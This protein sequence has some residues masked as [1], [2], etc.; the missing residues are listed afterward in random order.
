MRIFDT[1]F[2]ILRNG[3]YRFFDH[4]FVQ[5]WEMCGVVNIV[6]IVDSICFLYCCFGWI[7]YVFLIKSGG[8][9]SYAGKKIHIYVFRRKSCC[10]CCFCFPF[11]FL[12]LFRNCFLIF[13]YLGEKIMLFDSDRLCKAINQHDMVMVYLI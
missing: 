11:V 8:L 2:M 1:S 10:C 13:N 9:F 5:W 3:K 4:L 7:I 6:S 12:L